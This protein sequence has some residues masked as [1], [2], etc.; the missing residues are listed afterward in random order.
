MD[1]IGVGLLDQKTCEAHTS[2][3]LLEHIIS[4]TCQQCIA[5]T[6]FACT[7]FACTKF[8][9]TN[10]L[11]QYCI[12]VLH[13][14][15]HAQQLSQLILF[16]SYLLT[17]MSAETARHSKQHLTVS[18]QYCRTRAHTFW[19][20]L[21]ASSAAAR[22]D[23]AACCRCHCFTSLGSEPSADTI[24]CMLQHNHNRFCACRPNQMQTQQLPS[25]C[26][27]AEQDQAVQAHSSA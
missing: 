22:S 16:Q 24:A 27:A 7:K 2:T 23:S 4:Q 18:Q 5:Y 9:C 20:A 21:T 25:S 11:A 3:H 1:K 8:A 14:L 19:P 12:K 26:Q 17:Q 10:S 15:M 13:M 6:K